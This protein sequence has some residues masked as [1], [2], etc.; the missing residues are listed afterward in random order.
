M[1]YLAY[2]KWVPPTLCF[3]LSRTAPLLLLR[4]SCVRVYYE[5]LGKE[6]GEHIHVSWRV[7]ACVHTHTHLHAVCLGLEFAARGGS[8]PHFR[9]KSTAGVQRQSFGPT[10]QRAAQFLKASKAKCGLEGAVLRGSRVS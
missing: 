5:I 3:P 7:C 4:H 2:K 8:A 6:R 10:R 9:Q 1:F